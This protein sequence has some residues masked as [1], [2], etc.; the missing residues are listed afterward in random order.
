MS[1]R[2]LRGAELFARCHLRREAWALPPG[3]PA[4]SAEAHG[5]M[6]TACDDL[7]EIQRAARRSRLRPSN[8]VLLAP[9]TEARLS[10]LLRGDRAWPG[11]AYL[12]FVEN[13]YGTD[14][15]GLA[16]RIQSRNILRRSGAPRAGWA[17][18]V[19]WAPDERRLSP[20]DLRDDSQAAVGRAR[21]LGMDALAAVLSSRRGAALSLAPRVRKRACG[22]SDAKRHWE[23]DKAGE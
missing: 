6:E 20:A 5:D 18:G 2:I 8:R 7:A 14:P 10:P 13:P 21:S 22:K 16:G 15:A 3:A 23:L 4:L 9:G 12:R 19:A 11:L 17:D 1:R